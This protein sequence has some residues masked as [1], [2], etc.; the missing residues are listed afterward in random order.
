[1][2]PKVALK[3]VPKVVIEDN[4]LLRDVNDLMKNN[5][6]MSLKLRLT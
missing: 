6:D 5:P 2:P 4:S 3:I 1:M